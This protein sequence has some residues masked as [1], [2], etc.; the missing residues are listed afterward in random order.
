MRPTRPGVYTARRFAQ[1]RAPLGPEYQK[2]LQ[3]CLKCTF[4]FGTKLNS[5]G[6]QTAV[7]HVVVCEF[8]SMIERLA[9]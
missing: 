7:Y 8:P 4:E 9:V 6:L 3:K 1:G 2:I 5:N